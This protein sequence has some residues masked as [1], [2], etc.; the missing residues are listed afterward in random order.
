MPTIPPII[1]VTADEGIGSYILLL[2]L[3]LGAMKTGLQNSLDAT[4]L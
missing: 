2:Y 3:L 1:D 4:S